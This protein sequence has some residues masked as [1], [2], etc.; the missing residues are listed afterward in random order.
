MYYFHHTFSST[1]GGLAKIF[2]FVTKINKNIY[3]YDRFFF[4]QKR[5]QK[6]NILRNQIIKQF[7]FF[8]SSKTFETN[9][10]LLTEQ[11]YNIQARSALLQN[12]YKII[13]KRRE[14]IISVKGKLT[15]QEN[16]VFNCRLFGI[17]FAFFCM[18]VINL[19]WPRAAMTYKG[20]DQ[21][22]NIY[23]FSQILIQI[24][25]KIRPR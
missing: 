18:C 6:P 9:F 5:T 22:G 11:G 3:L 4:L 7:S 19:T 20:R 2:F 15:I 23:T 1:A 16:I 17:N 14:K 12:Q 8:S 24:T 10:G 13:W 21:H 25:K